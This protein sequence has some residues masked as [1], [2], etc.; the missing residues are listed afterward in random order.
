M[1]KFIKK[2][3][4]ILVL[5]GLIFLGLFYL[6]IKPRKLKNQKEVIV[7]D[8]LSINFNNGSKIKAIGN[9]KVSFKIINYT[10]KKA[11]YFIEFI[12]PHNVENTSYILKKDGKEYKKGK[13]NSFNTTITEY[14][15]IEPE[16]EHDYTLTFKNDKYNIYKI[17]ININEQALKTNTFS[18]IVIKNNPINVPKTSVGEEIAIENEGLISSYDDYGT[19][20]YFRGNAQNNYV[21]LD[22]FLFRILRINGD[23]SVRLVLNDVIEE[24]F[25]FY[26]DKDN[27]SFTSSDIK[28]GLNNWLNSFLLKYSKYIANHKYCEEKVDNKGSFKAY[29]RI[30]VDKNPSLICFGNLFS[31]KVAYLTADDVL[32]AGA[33][34]ND[35][36]KSF[37]LYNENITEKVYLMTPSFYQRDN[38]YPYVLN[39]KGKVVYDVVGTTLLSV[40]PVISIVKTATISGDGTINN[41]YILTKS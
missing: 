16:E 38:L 28:R 3:L 12:N 29:N 41:P 37:F 13:V 30:I 32:Y 7:T 10:K 17:T 15:S 40:R 21:K 8:F 22:D 33:T 14:I 39:E 2:V 5:G 4:I 19:A 27:I 11:N 25:K 24:K 23:G 26:E 9:K 31:S 36:N 20:Y 1:V 35:I 34:V 6:V 18:D